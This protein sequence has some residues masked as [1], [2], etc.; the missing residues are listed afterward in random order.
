MVTDKQEVFIKPIRPQDLPQSGH[1]MKLGLVRVCDA[2]TGKPASMGGIMFP[3]RMQG[4]AQVFK[5]DSIYV[6]APANQMQAF[7]TEF[8]ESNG[9][10]VVS[11]PARFKE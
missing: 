6:I 4:I 1:G 10:K 3:T 7:A 9:F 11:R 8:F 2:K 5:Y